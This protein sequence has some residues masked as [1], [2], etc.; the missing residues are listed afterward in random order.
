MS[1][2]IKP[3]IVLAVAASSLL[4]KLPSDVHAG[5]FIFLLVGGLWLTDSFH[6][7]ITALLVPALAALTGLMTVSE[8]A[9]HFASPVIVLFFGGFALA[10]ALRRQGLDSW[11]AHGLIRLARGE[12]RLT[13]LMLFL[14]TVLL[15]LWISNTATAAIM[16]PLALGLLHD[17]QADKRLCTFT[18][19]GVAWSAT[20]G[21][22]VTLIGSPPNAIAA[23]ALGWGFREWLAV[24]APVFALLYPL[25]LAVLW[26]VLR[27]P[28]PSQLTLTTMPSRMDWTPAHLKTLGIFLFTVL[29]WI[30]GH[31]PAQWLG[32]SADKDALA[33]LLAVILLAVFR[34]VSWDDLNKGTQWGVLLLFGGGIALSAVLQT[35]GT[36]SWLATLLHGI[37]PTDNLLL[38]MLIITTFVVF[39]SEFISNTACT[40]LLVPVMIPIAAQ[41][42]LPKEAMVPL[43]ALASSTAFMLPV[44]TPANALVYGT[45]HISAADMRRAGFRMNLLAIPV[46]VWWFVV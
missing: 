46:L 13:L 2:L 7:T 29:L 5:L 12:P 42:G 24:G 22:M 36:S 18:L 4:L 31:I 21:G 41:I 10:A 34:C 19:L 40:A 28:L 3:L 9:S 17:W 15:G 45:G 25:A 8:A 32:I 35:S 16:L 27:P 39:F 14:S 38:S 11:L 30:W 20:I 37:L 23:S 1:Y 6:L 33:A 26:L 43:I 44:A